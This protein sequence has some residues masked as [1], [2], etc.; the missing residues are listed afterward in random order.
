LK[1]LSA[2]S[3]DKLERQVAASMVSTRTVQNDEG[4]EKMKK[5]RYAL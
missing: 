3:G 4:K 2:H 5:L 1:L